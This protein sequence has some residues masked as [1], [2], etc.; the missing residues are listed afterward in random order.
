MAACSQMATPCKGDCAANQ[1]AWEANVTRATTAMGATATKFLY[2]NRTQASAL[3]V[4]GSDKIIVAMKG[5][6]LN[7]EPDLLVNPAT[8]LVNATLANRLPKGGARPLVHKGFSNASIEIYKEVRRRYVHALEAD[9]RPT[10][11]SWVPLG[12]EMRQH[13]YVPF[14]CRLCC[15]L[16][17]VKVLLEVDPEARLPVYFTG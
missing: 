4:V 12:L 7:G 14:C 11:H 10:G 17:L 13:A 6:V 8:V 2:A 16:Q 3:V 1:A 15:L 5:N 9:A